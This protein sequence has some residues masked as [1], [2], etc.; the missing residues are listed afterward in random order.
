MLQNFMAS[1]FPGGFGGVRQ[2]E[3]L[4]GSQSSD[5]AD[6]DGGSGRASATHDLRSQRRQRKKM[7]VA[8][9]NSALEKYGVVSADF[10]RINGVPSSAPPSMSSSATFELEQ[11][12]MMTEFQQQLEF[13]R[14]RNPATA[15]K[16]QERIRW[17]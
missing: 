13:W 10:G 7:R 17:V 12:K 16:I 8:A 15:A 2:N 11:I 5:G 4:H 6:G 9:L 1:E 3:Q 14:D